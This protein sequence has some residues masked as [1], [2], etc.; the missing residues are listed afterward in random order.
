MMRVSTA[1]VFGAYFVLVSSSQLS[2]GQPAPPAVLQTPEVTVAISV[3]PKQ[4]D[5]IAGGPVELEI[6]FTNKTAARIYYLVGNAQGRPAYVKFSAELQPGSRRLN[7]PYPSTPLEPDG[8]FASIPID[9]G[10]A[11][12]RTV[13]LNQYVALEDA[14]LALAPGAGAVLHVHWRWLVA[15]S[16]QPKPSLPKPRLVEGDFQIRLVR[17]DEAL[18]QRVKALASRLTSDASAVPR[19]AVGRRDAITALTSLRIPETEPYLRQLLDFPDFE[20]RSLAQRAIRTMR[21]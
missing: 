11:D 16:R 17:D 19:D 21:P 9:P 20:V 5:W 3:R 8:P 12:E 18:R 6:R 10:Q 4:Q 2:F 15:V 13:V 14:R 7:D 1:T